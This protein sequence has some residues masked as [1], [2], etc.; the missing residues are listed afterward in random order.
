MRFVVSRHGLEPFDAEAREFLENQIDGEPIEMEQLWPRDMHEQ[1]RIMGQIRELAKGLGTDFGKG[2][3][4]ASSRD[5]KLH[6]AW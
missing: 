2:A 3:R 4:R 5:R 6:A 1:R